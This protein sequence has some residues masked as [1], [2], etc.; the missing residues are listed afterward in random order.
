M[1]LEVLIFL[2][3]AVA[4]YVY[5]EWTKRV[6]SGIPY[7]PYKFPYGGRYL[8]KVVK[9]E[10]TFGLAVNECYPSMDEPLVGIYMIY[11]PVILV[12]D[13]DIVKMI[14]TTHFEHFS[15]RGMFT[16]EKKDPLSTNLFTMELDRWRA[17][18]SKLT[19]AFS[20][21]KI[22]QMMSLVQGIAQAY[23]KELLRQADNDKDVTHIKMKDM[24]SRL[25]VDII[26]STVFG[27][28]VN[29]LTN[30]D[31]S[32][33]KIAKTLSQTRNT[34][35]LE[36]VRF[37]CVFLWPKFSRFLGLGINPRFVTDYFTTLV[38]QTI[39]SR[40]QSQQVR[41]DVMQQLLQLRNTG[42]ID[43]GQM[44]A[45]GPKTTK[46]PYLSIE[47]CASNAFLFYVAGSESSTSTICFCLFEL[48]REQGHLKTLQDEIDQVLSAHNGEMSYEALK[49][50]RFLEKCILET[51]RKYP[52]LPMLNRRCTKQFNVPG[53]QQIIYENQTIMIPL[54]AIQ[55]DPRYF[56]NP[57]KFNPNRS[58]PQDPDY[59]TVNYTAFG[60]GPKSC[61]AYRLGTIMVKAGLVSLLSKFTLQRPKDDSE[62]EF[63]I[64]DLGMLPKNDFT[65]GLR[66]R[67]DVAC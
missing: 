17:L 9:R 54:R 15:D 55:T 43:N 50:M 8:E 32:F 18:R 61:I 58:D 33:R 46:T 64:G 10:K 31:H 24:S 22:G 20:G 45:S 3:S 53:T 57:L 11:K 13:P 38:R 12:R 52:A 67:E 4:F 28:E 39:E 23:Q 66:K 21:A 49:E 26:G 65:I 25:V 1:F 60:E 16:D 41:C 5:Q 44:N 48:S 59:S 51:L 27:I 30:E 29:S 37:L 63:S 19:P 14:M 6:R 34:E 35:F 40:E 62:L 2:V 36:A 56:P 7:L 42:S 47:E